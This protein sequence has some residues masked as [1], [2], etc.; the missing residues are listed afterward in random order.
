M[1]EKTFGQKFCTALVKAQ[2]EFP[3]LDMNGTV[4]V[5][6]KY[7]FKY[8]D[9]P[10]VITKVRPVL[11]RHGLAFMQLVNGDRLVTSVIHES[12]E[13]RD[14][15][16]PLKGLNMDEKAF[17]A[18]IT[19]MKRYGLVAALGLVA[20]EDPDG[21]FDPETSTNFSTRES[22]QRA[23]P[24]ASQA[25]TN[26]DVGNVVNDNPL[27]WR[28]PVGKFKGKTIQQVGHKELLSYLNF[29]SESGTKQLSGDMLTLSEKFKEAY[30]K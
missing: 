7:T 10:E 13:Y 4:E 22:A 25:T 17:G 12:G 29:V 23:K 8:A 5:R 28:I 26:V 2:K 15:Y 30:V 6:G 18:S 1:E 11:A 16:T 21:S 24:S 20:D 3:V 27:L 9:L 14:A 19:Y